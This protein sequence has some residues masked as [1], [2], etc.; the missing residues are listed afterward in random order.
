[1]IFIIA[2]F[3]SFVVNDLLCKMLYIYFVQGPLVKWLKVNFG[4]CF[5]AWIHTK[6]L[7]VFVESVLR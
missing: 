2:S 4:E 1:M 5:T 3:I 6:A 7:R